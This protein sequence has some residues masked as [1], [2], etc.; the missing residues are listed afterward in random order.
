[1]LYEVITRYEAADLL[2]DEEWC[3]FVN[4]SY[5]TCFGLNIMWLHPQGAYV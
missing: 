4:Q 2:I 3:F 5:K 1:M